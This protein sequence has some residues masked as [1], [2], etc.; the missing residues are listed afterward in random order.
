MRFG[1]DVGTIVVQKTLSLLRCHSSARNELLA[2]HREE[3]EHILNMRRHQADR[4][5]GGLEWLLLGRRGWILLP[6]IVLLLLSL[7]RLC[8]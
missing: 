1:D 4:H 8:L 2:R 3:F 7:K 6:S 5:F